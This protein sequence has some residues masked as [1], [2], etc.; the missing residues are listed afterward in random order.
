MSLVA[1]ALCSA[2]GDPLD[3]GLS[4]FVT[5]LAALLAEAGYGVDAH[6]YADAD[7]VRDVGGLR[8]RGHGVARLSR[9]AGLQSI[10][11]AT[12]RCLYA[13]IVDQPTPYKAGSL[14][15]AHGV[16]WARPGISSPPEMTHCRRALDEA[17]L[18]VSIGPGFRNAIRAIDP[19]RADR[20]E[21]APPMA[22]AR[23]R[24]RAAGGSGSAPGSS[25]PR[26]AVATLAV[27]GHL[28]G[29]A[30]ADV[31][32]RALGPIL[33]ARPGV[34]AVV[35]LDPG[36]SG[37]EG[38]SVLPARARRTALAFGALPE[39]YRDAAVAVLGPGWSEDLV[40]SCLGAMASGCA[41]VAPDGAGLDHLVIHGFN[42]L[43]V[44]WRPEALTAACGRLLDDAG[45]CARLGA[46]AARTAAAFGPARWAAAWLRVVE[47]V[48]GPG[49]AAD[50]TPAVESR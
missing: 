35:A 4:P 18:V 28:D 45:L 30:Q 20:I 46:E 32:A 43:L 6:Q 34:A 26:T 3:H 41:V 11:H 23:F 47:R 22:D 39:L 36:A 10:H 13:S 24:P 38:L 49:A 21:V 9:L 8:V 31:L 44:P 37:A 29:A 1:P 19:A 7:W 40:P 33:E 15:V 27:A 12:A 16:W 42:G 2:S 48:Y 17:A 25:D 14:V 50:R 5:A